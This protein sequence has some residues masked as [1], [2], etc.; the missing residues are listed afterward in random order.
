MLKD[1][2]FKIQSFE[3]NQGSAVFGITLNPEAD[4]YKAHFPGHP[5]TPGVC[6]VQ[7]VVELL[8]E[9]LKENHKLSLAKNI[10]YLQVISPVDTP[11][12]A[13]EL[14]KIVVDGD[15]VSVQATISNDVTLFTKMSI[16]C[17]K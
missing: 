17:T 4:I 14:K 9:Y 11:N 12:I 6:I 10:K 3:D 1:I 7:I 15:T 16:Q 5:I 13:V 2:L 8:N